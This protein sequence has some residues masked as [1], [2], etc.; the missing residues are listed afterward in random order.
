[1][2]S[3][4]RK[5]T[6]ASRP[7]ITP[8]TSG[9]RLGHR[10]PS[11]QAL[12]TSS[13]PPQTPIVSSASQLHTPYPTDTRIETDRSVRATDDDFDDHVI[14]AI[15]MKDHG[16]VGCSYYSAEEEKMYLLGDSRSG[17]MET[18]D[19][20]SSAYLPYQIDIRPTPEFSYS[21]AESKLLA[22]QIS[23]KHEQRIR[24]FVP[25][26]GLAGPEEVDPEEM[27][28]TLQE[29]RLLHISSS[30][31]ME[32]PVTI[33]CAG[34]I[35]T[36]LQRR[37]AAAPS[38]LEEGNEY[39][40]RALQ[41]FNLRDTMWISSNTFTSLQIIQSESHPNMFNQG[42]GKKS[43]SGKEGLSV[44]GLFQHFAY[45]PQGRARLKQTFFRPSVNLDTIRER[46][47]FIGVFSSPDNLAALDKMTKA[48]K[49][50]K[51]LRPVMV[52]LRKGIST[53]S[54]K[55]TGFKTTVWASLLAA[56]RVFEA[57]QLYRVGRMVQEIVDI[58]NSEEQGRTVVKQGIDREL[59]KIKDRYDGLNS[60]LKHVALDIAATIPATLNVDVNVIY[61]P[62]LGFNIAIPLNG[63]GTA[64]YTGSDDDWELMFI[65]ENR[66]YFKDFR[67]REMDEKL[68]D[69]YGIICEKEIEIVYDLAQRVLRYENVLVD[70]SDICGDI[71]SLLALTQ[72]ASFYK[73]T[74]PR[75]VEQN[76]IRIKG[77]RHILQEL[78]VSSYVPNDTFLVGGN[79]SETND[80]S[81]STDSN[82]SMLLLTGPNYSGKS[83]YIKQVALIVYL[84]QIGSFVPADSAELGVT[85]KILTKINTQESV[86]KIQSTFMNDLQQISLCLKQ[87]TNRSLI[88][89]DEFGK[90]TNE[91]DGIG[92]ACGILDYLLCLESPAKVIAATHFHEI[93]ENNFLALRPRLHLGHMEVQVCE[94]TQE[95]EDQ[96]T[97]LYN[98]RPGRSNKS[99]GTICA[100]INGIDPAIV[101]RANE[102]AS[103][104]ARGENIVAACAVLSSEEMQDLEE[105]CHYKNSLARGFLEIDF[106]QGGPDHV[107]AVFEG[108]FE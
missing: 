5:R 70:A 12:S 103:L 4:K 3:L 56:L 40:I 9:R 19:A 22:L 20:L 102:I 72:A 62:Q 39:R 45:T 97:Y 75:M 93:F 26:N 87:V 23:S 2:S 51:N 79:E 105:A 49:H 11:S 58:D 61:F 94:E 106:S 14:A 46:H 29:G 59:D 33:G 81:S 90:G 38:P 63:H 37:R 1:M 60:L 77:G 68:G 21:N 100:A 98:F 57:A 80:A 84:A 34:A 50:I 24:F 18:I 36:Y 13:G 91:S 95:V 6:P 66:A 44:Y 25:Q 30:V 32:N 7:P 73:L 74:R 108:L 17:D 89:I 88:I 78:T 83:V 99:F 92:L 42:P 48:L 15:D 43:A 52:N 65:T 101:S 8:R 41:M 76:V 107:K 54:A 47:D 104:S 82:P 86:S 16:T 10:A 53:G 55:I 27:G 28:F 71:D 85:D 35:L 96:I 69:I 31:D 67:M 64:E